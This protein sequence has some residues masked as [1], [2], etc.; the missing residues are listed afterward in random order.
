MHVEAE[1]L[2]RRGFEILLAEH[3]ERHWGAMKAARTKKEV[4]NSDAE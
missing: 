1:E 2:E 4:G 3:M